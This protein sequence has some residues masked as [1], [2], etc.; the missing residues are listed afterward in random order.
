MIAG[1]LLDCTTLFLG[2]VPIFRFLTGIFWLAFFDFG[3]V[4]A[5]S[6]EAIEG[7][8]FCSARRKWFAMESN[9]FKR[10]KITYR[11][12]LENRLSKLFHQPIVIEVVVAPFFQY[13]VTRSSLLGG[14]RTCR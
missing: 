4:R 14:T 13:A 5:D 11:L 9:C 2:C 7:R 10:Y 1:D 3:P 12:T 8:S 6:R